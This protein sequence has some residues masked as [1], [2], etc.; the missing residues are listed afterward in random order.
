MG[1]CKGPRCWWLWV[2]GCVSWCGCLCWV[3]C[4]HVLK[5]TRACVC[6]CIEGAASG[7]QLCAFIHPFTHTLI[8][9]QTSFRGR[10]GGWSVGLSHLQGPRPTVRGGCGTWLLLGSPGLCPQN[11]LCWA[12]F[13]SWWAAGTRTMTGLCCRCWMPNSL[14][15]C[16]TAWTHRMP[17]ASSGS[18]SPGHL[19]IPP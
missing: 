7:W 16:S 13:G 9:S 11:S 17:K 19:I 4:W 10:Q 15:T 1:V 5:A 14:A 3:I 12:P 18:S 8:E 6:V 2:H